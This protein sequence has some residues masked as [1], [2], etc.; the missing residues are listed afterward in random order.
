MGI[1]ELNRGIGELN[2]GISHF[3]YPFNNG[4]SISHQDIEGERYPYS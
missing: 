2:R 1:G 4:Y 3:Y